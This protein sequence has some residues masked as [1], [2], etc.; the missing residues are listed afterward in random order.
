MVVQLYGRTLKVDKPVVQGSNRDPISHDV[1]LLR[2]APQLHHAYHHVWQ[3]D[4]A[5]TVK[6][7]KL[8]EVC[9]S[10][11]CNIQVIQKRI[12]APILDEKLEVVTRDR[13]IRHLLLPGRVQMP[14]PLDQLRHLLVDIPG[15]V[16]SR[17]LLLHVVVLEARQRRLDEKRGNDIEQT[18][19]DAYHSN[20]IENVEAR[21]IALCKVSSQRLSCSSAAITDETSEQCEH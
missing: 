21:A 11:G 3:G 13:H 7:N 4:H 19:D 16:H 2:I 8:K 17:I 20:T 18:E 12:D 9:P 5:I 10:H 1:A 15:L 6:V 14:N